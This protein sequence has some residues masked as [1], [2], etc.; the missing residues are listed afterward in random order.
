MSMQLLAAAAVLLLLVVLPLQPCLLKLLASLL[1]QQ[2]VATLCC[3][4][5]PC[6]LSCRLKAGLCRV[7]QEEVP[8]ENKILQLY[9]CLC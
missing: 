6:V 8:P 3:V 7:S 9:F 4:M 2:V 5:G 1:L